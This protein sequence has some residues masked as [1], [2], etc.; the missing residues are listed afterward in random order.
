M[1][2]KQNPATLAACGAPVTDQADGSITPDNSH[3][4][5]APQANVQAICDELIDAITWAQTETAL[6]AALR[7]ALARKAVSR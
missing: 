3:S 1:A 7:R 5:G 6:G 4:N 2:S